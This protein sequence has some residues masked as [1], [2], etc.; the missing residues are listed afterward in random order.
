MAEL[1]LHCAIR[2][3]AGHYEAVWARNSIFQLLLR[4]SPAI[5]INRPY[6]PATAH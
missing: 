1:F 3:N 6:F 5:W 4:P 2:S